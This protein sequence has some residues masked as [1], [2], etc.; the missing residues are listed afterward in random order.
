MVAT[1]LFV[2]V[3]KWTWESAAHSDSFENSRKRGIPSISVINVWLASRSQNPANWSYFRFICSF[4]ELHDIP[5]VWFPSICEFILRLLKASVDSHL[6]LDL[7][8]VWA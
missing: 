1:D 6:K 4:Q 7:M 8:I 3:G 2:V 5:L